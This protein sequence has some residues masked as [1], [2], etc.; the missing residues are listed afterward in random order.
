MIC[1]CFLFYA[2]ILYATFANNAAKTLSNL[3]ALD[4]I[5]KSVQTV[6]YLRIQ[7]SVRECIMQGGLSKGAS[8]MQ[9]LHISFPEANF[10]SVLC[11]R[12]LIEK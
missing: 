10:V 1:R 7:D 8:C 6:P 9:I 4:T 11:G 5:P 12:R 3:M 2:H